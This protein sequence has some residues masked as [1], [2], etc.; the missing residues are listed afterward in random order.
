MANRKS[1]NTV[2]I[3]VSELD[4]IY[5]EIKQLKL[6]IE[7]HEKAII[8]L[9]R[10]DNI[11][12]NAISNIQNFFLGLF[13]KFLS[14]VTR[15]PEESTNILKWAGVKEIMCN[16]PNHLSRFSINSITKYCGTDPTCPSCRSLEKRNSEFD[17][18]LLNFL[19]SKDDVNEDN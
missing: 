11:A 1:N 16:N 19:D 3:K 2:E 14:K 17:I 8:I 4:L 18:S 10:N 12:R 13:K 7:S 5:S 6:R 9:Q 15:E